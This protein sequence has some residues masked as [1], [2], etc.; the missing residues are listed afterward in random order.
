LAVN[1]IEKLKES[2]RLFAQNQVEK[3]WMLSSVRGI[4]FMSGRINDK[5]KADIEL[6]SG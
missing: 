6:L 1:L 2:T 3:R 5:I 4:Q